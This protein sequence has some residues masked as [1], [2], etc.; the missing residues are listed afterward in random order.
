MGL[1]LEN[2]DRADDQGGDSGDE[3]E[4]EMIFLGKIRGR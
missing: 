1:I 2:S 4:S 3:S